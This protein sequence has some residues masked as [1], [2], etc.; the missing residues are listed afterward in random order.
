MS[1]LYLNDLESI[2]NGKLVR[3]NF[4]YKPKNDKEL[5]L[6]KLSK[7][8]E[9]LRYI[10][11]IILEQFKK[12]SKEAL[13]PYNGIIKEEENINFDHRMMFLSKYLFMNIPTT[14]GDVGCLLSDKGIEST[15]SAPTSE[16]EKKIEL[17][18]PY[19]RGILRLNK[20]SNVL[21]NDFYKDINLYD[22]DSKS[23]IINGDGIVLPFRE[24]FDLTEEEKQDLL[25]YYYSNWNKILSKINIP[26]EEVLDNFRTNVSKQKALAIYKNME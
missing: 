21:S 17:L 25:G 3:M 14:L 16:L 7:Q 24:Y 26:D 13:K 18:R 4:G 22:E 20:E 5:T 11:S 2:V 23:L 19:I 15:T 8:I 9:D 6:A 1:K 12:D 10:R